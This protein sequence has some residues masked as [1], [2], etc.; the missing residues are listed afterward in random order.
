MALDPG[1]ANASS[2]MSQLIF[3]QMDQQLKDGVPPDTLEDVR[4]SWRKLAFAIASGVV[5]HLKTSMDVKGIQSD[6]NIS[7]AISQVNGAAAT[8]TAAGHITLTQT[9][10]TSG[11]VA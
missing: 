4:K 9:A 11:H 7:V 5:Q 1:D 6:G 3:A 10:V 2:G 8:G